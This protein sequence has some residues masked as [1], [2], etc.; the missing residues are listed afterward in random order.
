MKKQ[1][2]EIEV[3]AKVRNFDKVLKNLKKLGC[4]MSKPIN[5]RDYCFIKN[6]ERFE[7]VKAGSQLFRIRVEDDRALLTLKIRQEIELSAIEKELE[8]SDKKAMREIFEAIGYHE[9]M[10]VIKVRRICHYKKYEICLDTV[11]GLGNFIEVEKMSGGKDGDV[12]EELFRFLESLGVKREDR[13]KRGYDTLT[14]YK[15]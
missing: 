9:I 14:Y 11:R 4:E 8:I 10:Q 15:K 1:V 5:Q 12:Q 13:E 7:D 2:K 6:G 3:K